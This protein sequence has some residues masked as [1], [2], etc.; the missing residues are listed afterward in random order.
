MPEGPGKINSEVSRD[1]AA[2]GTEGVSI[3][4]QQLALNDTSDPKSRFR[5]SGQQGDSGLV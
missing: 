4:E 3:V 2:D 5:A 1:G